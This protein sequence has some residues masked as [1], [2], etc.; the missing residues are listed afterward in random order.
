MLIHPWDAA[1]DAD[2]WRQFAIA[3]GFGHLI[4]AGTGRR[5]PVVVPTQFVFD[6][7]TTPGR[8]PYTA[9]GESPDTTPGKSP[10]SAPREAMGTVLLHLARPNPIWPALAENPYAVLAIAGDWAY[11]PSAWKAVDGEDPALGVP[12]T[13]YAA[14]QL[15]GEVEIIDDPAAKLDLLRTQLATLQ[16]DGGHAD[17]AAHRRELNGIRGIRLTIDDVQA[18]FKYGGNVDAAHR[19]AV[20]DRL[21]ERGAPGDGAARAHLIR[22]LERETP[23]P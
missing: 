11:V 5:R 13:Y 16:P 2:E 23:C 4:A 20:A 22:R 9:P 18:K 3:Q 1:R 10:D 15:S 19:R 8:L 12:T 7:D 14:V 21:S 17:P 6:R